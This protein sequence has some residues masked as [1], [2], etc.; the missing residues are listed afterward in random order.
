MILRWISLE[1][2]RW[3]IMHAPDNPLPLGEPAVTPEP[4]PHTRVIAG[5]LE[6]SRLFSGITV[7]A[8]VEPTPG[9]AASEERT[10]PQSYVLDLKM[11]VR[12]PQPNATLD[13]LAKVNPELSRLL[14]GL[15]TLITPDSVSPFFNEFYETKLKSLR[16]SLTRLDQ[17]LSRHNF[18]D[19]QT[20]L[21]LRDPNSK[22]KAILM[23]A[24]MDSDADGSDADR[25]PAG[26]G[27]S[28]NFQPFTSYKWPKKTSAANPYLA[29]LEEKARRFETEAANKSTNAER[30]RELKAAI[31]QARDEIGTLKAFSFLIGANDPFIVIP[32]GL[33]KV[34]GAK[35]GDY[36]VVV[37][38]NAIYPAIV[39]DIGPADKT[40]EAS[41]RI[42]KEI[43]ASATANI[44][45]VDDLKVTYLIFP[46][47]A[48][49]PF[50]PPNLEKI[51][52]RCEA[53][54]NEIGGAGVP[55]HK[56]VSTI[57]TP[58]PT[59][60]PTPIPTPSPS[61]TPSATPETSPGVSPSPTFAFPLSSPSETPSPSPS[62]SPSATAV[63]RHSHKKSA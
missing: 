32:A 58:T 44:R 42:A 40:G 61:P 24:D 1:R 63:V 53:L 39:G 25:L 17:L 18:Y 31:T 51:T 3:S 8:A 27:V 29:T 11:Q 46:G 16:Q 5:R 12:T 59:P 7:H 45:A 33:T 26:S 37:S 9:R 52:A 35:V 28:P 4:R 20:V 56:W 10:D 48:E 62:P 38:E 34:E 6:T 14:P 13:D 2:W 55:L 30:K 15:A 43:S 19:C 54:V 49:T 47:T 57:P 50:G 22:R 21:Q 36:A 41:L 60:T 23:Q